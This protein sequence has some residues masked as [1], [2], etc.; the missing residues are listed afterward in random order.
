MN[1]HLNFNISTD[2]L[3]TSAGKALGAITAKFL[4]AKGLGFKTYILH[5]YETTVLPI[6]LY[7]SAT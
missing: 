7:T 2:P 6:M 3:S 5:I 4:K 1:E